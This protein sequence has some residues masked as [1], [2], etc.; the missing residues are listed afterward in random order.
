VKKLHFFGAF[1]FF[2]NEKMINYLV[3]YVQKVRSKI[4]NI[5][6][7][8]K[9][10][11]NHIICLLLVA[12]QWI[13]GEEPPAEFEFAQSTLQAFYFFDDI[14]LNG[15]SIQ[16]DDWVGVFNGEICVGAR[17]WDTGS[18]GGGMC[19]IPAMGDDGSAYT[20]GYLQA[21]D[22]PTFKIYD[23]SSGNVFN[24]IPSADVDSWFINE[25]FMNDLLEATGDMLGCVDETACNYDSD[26]TG[27]DGSCEYLLGCDE[28]CGS[29]LELDECGVCGGDGPTDN[30]DCDGNCIV[31]IDCLGDCGGSAV[32]DNCDNC[33]TDLSNDC[34]QDCSGEWGGELVEDACGV[35]NG[36]NTTCS[37]CMDSESANFNPNATIDDGSC[38][39]NIYANYVN[40][41]SINSIYPNPFNPVVNI[42]LN[43]DIAGH[44]QLTVLNIQGELIKT[45]YN[46]FSSIGGFKFTWTPEN[47]ASGY[48]FINAILDNRVE[49]QKVLFLK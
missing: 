22:I 26:A 19:D 48:Y 47:M 21:G 29:T 5:F 14:T 33:D 36:D 3:L 45:I 32:I 39:L 30:F 18:C 38:N 34:V 16:S 1:S 20:V 17:L 12:L 44:L 35:C 42:D 27:D 13:S 25:F 28:I 8:R 49:V 2:I 4:M 15:N 46:G 9:I 11:K 24:A 23:T 31:D 41:F 43:I 37:G 6:G 40:N 10:K 7:R